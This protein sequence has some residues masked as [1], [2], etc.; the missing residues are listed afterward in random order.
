MEETCAEKIAKNNAV[1]REANDDLAEAATE[2]GL[3]GDNWSPFICECSDTSCVK[4]VRLT[5]E[6]YRHVRS[7]PRWFVHAPEHETTVDGLVRPV[8]RH[9][10][11]TMV[12]K[13]GEAGDLAAELASGREEA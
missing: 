7:N 1:F 4:V 3:A 12:E 2:F 11:Y 6:E 9:E 8:E 10:G 5:L 13:I